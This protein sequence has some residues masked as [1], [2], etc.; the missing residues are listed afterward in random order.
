MSS[1]TM[2][3]MLGR[4]AFGVSAAA[5]TAQKVIAATIRD[6]MKQRIGALS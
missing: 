4:V 6:R 2:T 3:R 1:A 5:G